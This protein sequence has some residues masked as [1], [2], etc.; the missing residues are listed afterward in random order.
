MGKDKPQSESWLPGV[1]Q[2]D[3][4]LE[5]SSTACLLAIVEHCLVDQA[6]SLSSLIVNNCGYLK[7]TDTRTVLLTCHY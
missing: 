1:I 2:M 5:K 6:G 3:E 4:A 7:E